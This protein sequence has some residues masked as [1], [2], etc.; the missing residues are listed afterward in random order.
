MEKRWRV[1]AGGDTLFP[2]ARHVAGLRKGK[3]IKNATWTR[4]WQPRRF[5]PVSVAFP[6][7]PLSL[8]RQGA[9]AL[10][11]GNELLATPFT[12]H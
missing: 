4:L 8:F 9:I 11:V 3:T 6:T 7:V 1:P 2:S 10:L 5:W 12:L